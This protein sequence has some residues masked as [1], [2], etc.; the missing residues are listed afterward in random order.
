MGHFS[1]TNRSLSSTNRSSHYGTRSSRKG[2][3]QK[4]PSRAK[5]SDRSSGR[6]STRNIQR[7]HGVPLSSPSSTTASQHSAKSCSEVPET[8]GDNTKGYSDKALEKRRKK[9]NSHLERIEQRLDTLKLEK[10]E[11]MRLRERQLE[12]L[13]RSGK[14]N[15]KAPPKPSPVLQGATSVPYFHEYFKSH[16]IKKIRQ[17][18]RRAMQHSFSAHQV[19]MGAEPKFL[20]PSKTRQIGYT[21]PH[22]TCW[23]SETVSQFRL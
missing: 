3:S 15:T 12:A 5:T 14:I 10:E 22:H 18:E 19:G 20:P 13:S 1:Q 9:L 16:M 7:G 21:P 4:G 17:D 23:G 6:K 8:D 2:T 11:N